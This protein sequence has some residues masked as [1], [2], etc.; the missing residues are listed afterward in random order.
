PS[1]LI[2][3]R[4]NLTYQPHDDQS[5]SLIRK[6]GYVL[7][8]VPNAKL[9]LIATGS[10]VELAVKAQQALAAEGIAARVVSMPCTNVF[11]RQ[12]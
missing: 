8:D 12:D 1:T 7:T 5:Q 3:S 10:E 11:D 9:V 6:G 2:F 4:Q